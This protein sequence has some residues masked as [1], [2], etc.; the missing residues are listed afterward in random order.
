[1]RRLA[2]LGA[3]V[4][5]ALAGVPGWTD[6]GGGPPPVPEPGFAHPAVNDVIPQPCTADPANPYEV[7]QYRDLEGWGQNAQGLY[8]R[9]PGDC[10]RLHLKLGPIAVKPG[11]NDV[12]IQPITIE[13]PAYD[14]Y[15]VRFKPDL[16]L[17]TGEIPGV[18]EIHL[19]HGTWI[20][21]TNSYFKDPFFASGEEKTIANFPRGYGFPIR[22]TDQWQLLHM[23]H[24]TGPQ[25]NSVYITYDIDYIAKEPAETTWS[26]TQVYPVWLDVRPSFY[27]VFN[28]QRGY[29]SVNPDTEKREC[30]W[31]KQQ[32]AAF[33]PWLQTDVVGQGQPGNGRGADW[34]LPAKGSTLGRV[35]NFQ[36]GTLIGIGGHLHPGGLNDTIELVRT[37][38]SGTTSC[39][40]S[41][42]VSSKEI[43]ISDAK[44]WNHDPALRDQPTGPPTSWDMSMTVT[45]A[46][47]WGVRVQPCDKLRINATYDSEI[48]STYENMGIAIAYIA[49]H[50]ANG[51]PTAPGVD[52]FA[53]GLPVDPTDGCQSGG[54]Q[55]SPPQLCLRGEVT[56]GH[57][58]ESQH[59][60][61]PDP[62]GVPAGVVPADT[63]T[64]AISAFAYAPGGIAQNIVDAPTVEPGG[65][66]RFVNLDAAANVYHTVTSCAYPCTGPTGIEFPLADG[67][68]SLGGDV[69]FDSG[70]L[71]FQACF[72]PNPLNGSGDSC[73]GPARNTVEWD[74][75]IGPEFQAGATYTYFC[76]IHPQMRG[77]FRVAA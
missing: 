68:S 57:L 77:A 27:P 13:K 33:D 76:R 19:H 70:E 52:P 20:S 4:A 45:G 2:A 73:T 62:G 17:A 21:L 49:P 75:T 5:I 25:P 7:E 6:G 48:A 36:G 9:Y 12:L 31:P 34:S 1:M 10:Q 35:Q 55:A 38:K 43:F 37:T 54:L 23:V 14:G 72:N 42:D 29:G 53:S 65:R 64:V 30:T 32:C 22:G 58:A 8:E 44:Y 50:A 74:L 46:P 39:G 41:S 40:G 63:D 18:E 11:Q 51:D 61:G 66:L 59:Y 69:D 71:G 16:Q 26:L 47:L 15:I 56:H 24:N 67:R 28:V 3:V 60:G